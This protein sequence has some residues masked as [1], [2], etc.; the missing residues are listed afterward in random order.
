M[1]CF[2]DYGQWFAEDGPRF[3]VPGYLALVL[4]ALVT[5]SLIVMAFRHFKGGGSTPPPASR[6][7]RDTLEILRIRLAKG[8][9]DEKEYRR[10][11]DILSV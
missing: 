5:L 6:D 2:I 7:A 9:I 11:R 10:I 3:S 1:T 8:E 4:L